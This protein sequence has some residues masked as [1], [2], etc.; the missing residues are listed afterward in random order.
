[1][2]FDSSSESKSAGASSD[3]AL[4]AAAFLC[5]PLARF[6]DGMAI[7]RSKLQILQLWSFNAVIEATRQLN[8][9]PSSE[10]LGDGLEGMCLCPH[11]ALLEI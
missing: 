2:H 9:R 8:E 5:F 11:E 3:T 7:G 1:M 6:L 10:E 4:A